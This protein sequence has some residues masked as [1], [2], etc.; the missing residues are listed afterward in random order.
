MKQD[1]KRKT[2]NLIAK[3]ATPDQIC[4]YKHALLLHKTYN[5]LDQV[6]DWLAHNLNQKFNARNPKFISADTS[7][8]KIGRNITSNR[9]RIIS[10]RINLTDLNDK[11]PTF[12]IKIKYLFLTLKDV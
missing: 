2:A 1:R 8:F 11:M 6:K 4:Q 10:N 7:N 5:N 12:K 9:L 3:R